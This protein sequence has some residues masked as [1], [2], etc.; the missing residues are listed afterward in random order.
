[1]TAP[2][3]TLG[4]RCLA[5]GLGTY[6]LVLFGCGAVHADVLTGAQKGVWQVAIVWG[7]I[8]TLVIYC[9][10]AISGAHINPAITIALAVW[11]DFPLRSVV[12]YIASQLLGA[13]LAGAT[14]FILYEPQLAQHEANKKVDRG[15]TGSEVSAMCYGEYFPNPGAADHGELYIKGNYDEL[16]RRVPPV[17]AFLAEFLG[18]LILGLMIFA[19]TDPA[20][21]SAP[22][23]HLAPVFIGLTVAL[24][25]SIIAP[26]T[27]ACFNPARD[28]GPRLFAYQAGWGSIAIPGPNGLHMPLVYVLAPIA[29][30]CAGGAVYQLVLRP[31]LL[32]TETCSDE[33][34]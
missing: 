22:P 26:L 13:F 4:M 3:P 34:K 10:A 21:R 17:A 19:L 14:L 20:N 6:L 1:M 25:I 2:A 7:V 16:A 32:P 5:E 27:Q 29:G 33:K 18:T 28:F 31:A 23:A 11:R 30:A 15:E 12:P 24:L 9:I 8:I